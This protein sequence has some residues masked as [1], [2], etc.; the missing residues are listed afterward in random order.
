MKYSDGASFA[1]I[2][3]KNILDMRKR[4]FKSPEI[5]TCLAIRNRKEAGVAETE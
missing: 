5:G 2:W 3:G 4:I 1:D